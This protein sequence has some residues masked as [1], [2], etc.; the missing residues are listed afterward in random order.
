[1]AEGRAPPGQRETPP[2]AGNLRRSPAD[3]R[4]PA[5][6][7]KLPAPDAEF[8]ARAAELYD[9]HLEGGGSD[10]EESNREFEGD[11]GY[12]GFARLVTFMDGPPMFM[13]EDA[14][15]TVVV[16]PEQAGGEADVATLSPAELKRGMRIALL[17]GSE[18]GGLL[19]EL[20]ATWDEGFASVRLRY[21]TLYR[22]ALDAAV[23]KHGI[24]GV[25]SIVGLTPLAVK[26]WADGHTWPGTGPT[27]LKLL[28]ASGDEEALATSRS[29]TPTSTRCAARTGTSD[30]CSTT[31]SARPCCTAAPAAPAS[32]SSNARRPRPHRHLRR[33]LRADRG[34][35]LRT[36]G[37]AR[38]VSGNF[39]DRDDPYLTAKGV[40]Q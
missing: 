4:G 10:G 13:R 9:Q 35:R 1:M 5:R 22:R 21:E 39:L 8:W 2:G 26:F 15:C 7:S 29:S 34:E 25:A 27:L 6:A 18:R 32:P 30:G 28:E 16:P 19:A 11:G 14:D 40:T 17:P 36:Q 12:S 31:Q 24:A 3:A 37:G 33:D 38:S 20:M 23:A